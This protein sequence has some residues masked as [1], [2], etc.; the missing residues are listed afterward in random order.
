LLFDVTRVRCAKQLKQVKFQL[1]G[2]ELAEN[3]VHIVL[4]RVSLLK[5]HHA[6]EKFHIR[7]PARDGFESLFSV[8]DLGEKFEALVSL[9]LRLR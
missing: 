9:S 4:L 7:A 6:V 5:H 8:A 2:V 3:H 1:S